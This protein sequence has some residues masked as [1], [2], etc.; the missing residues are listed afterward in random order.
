MMQTRAT[1]LG[2]DGGGTTTD[3]ALL[4]ADG[5]LLSRTQGTT[6]NKSVVGLDQ[7]ASILTSLIMEACTQADIQPPITSGWIGLAGTD[8]E[9]DRAAFRETLAPLFVQ[10]RITNDA[11]LVL[12]GTP[13]GTGIA[14][15]G[16]TG[17]IAFARNKHGEFGR[18]G[19]WGHIFGDEGSA[20]ALGVDAL[21]AVAAATDKR[22]PETLLSQRLMDFWNAD[23]PQQLIPRVYDTTVQKS[24]IA[25]SAPVV[26]NTGRDGDGVTQRL[27][28]H[29]AGDLAD[30]VVSL[31]HRISFQRPPKVVVTGGLLLHS[32]EIRNEVIA[33]L[34]SHPV[35]PGLQPVDDI[36]VS[37]AS[38]VHRF[39]MKG[40]Q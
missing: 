6:S 37:A 36:A 11:E 32:D 15:I 28:E 21:R 27:L 9:E 3:L 16:G 22:G 33:R 19:G 7:A 23:T 30:M 17:S 2:I 8:R 10:L 5:T 4:N 24:D 25:A 35:Q 1:F 12:S 18:S 31:L 39:F 14:L 29:T 26:V 34:A 20:Y 38:A 13:D 40:S